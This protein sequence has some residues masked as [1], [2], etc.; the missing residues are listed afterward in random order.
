MYITAS[1]DNRNHHLRFRESFAIIIVLK[2]FKCLLS[3]MLLIFVNIY[4]RN[5]RVYSVRYQI[6]WA[7]KKKKLKKTTFVDLN[8]KYF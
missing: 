8:K 6:F 7:T 3:I 4:L 2:F 1:L 5:I